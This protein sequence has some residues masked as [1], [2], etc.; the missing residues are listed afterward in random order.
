V[1]IASA[2]SL[3]IADLAGAVDFS[4]VFAVVHELP[5]VE[6]FFAEL[7]QASKPGAGLLLVEPVGHVKPVQFEAELQAAAK[8]GF[9]VVD[10]PSI[11]RSRAALLKKG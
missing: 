3:S 2:N 4:L 1:R 6:A 9:V 8:A 10:R 5:A 11:R 7:A